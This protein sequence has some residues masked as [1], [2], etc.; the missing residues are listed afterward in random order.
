MPVY[1]PGLRSWFWLSSISFAVLIIFTCMSYW[2]CILMREV[3]SSTTLT[4]LHSSAPLMSLTSSLSSAVP[5]LLRRKSPSVPR[6][7]AVFS[8]FTSYILRDTANT[9][10]PSP[11][12]LPPTV[13]SWLISIL[14]SAGSSICS[15]E[16]SSTALPSEVLSV[17]S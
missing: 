13:P 7:I 9:S 11:S 12:G 17:P 3:I 14:E 5:P 8:G 1:A 6:Y 2:R 4:L 15:P 16:S 10:E